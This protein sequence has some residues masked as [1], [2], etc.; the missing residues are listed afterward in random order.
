[1]YVVHVHVRTVY[2]VN[3]Y[4]S[5]QQADHSIRFFDSMIDSS[6]DDALSALPVPVGTYRYELVLCKQIASVC[7]ASARQ[8]PGTLGP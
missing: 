3:T 4:D 8:Y 1:M 2:H 6:F 5:A 7:S